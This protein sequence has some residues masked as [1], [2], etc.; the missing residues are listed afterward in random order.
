MRLARELNA[1]FAIAGR[2][3]MN[4]VRQPQYLG[5][6]FIFPIIFIGLLGG[7][8]S[9]NLGQNLGF[10]LL[11]FV[12]IGM[13]V[14]SIYQG[15]MSGIT[16]LIEDREN[17]FTQEMFVA[18][19]SRYSIILGKVLGSGIMSVVTLVSV[20]IVALVMGVSISL[21]DVGHIL[22]L[23]PII[24]LSGSALGIFFIGFVRS[25]RL[26]DVG[27]FLLVFPQIF[28]SGAMIPVHHSSGALNWLV[29]AMPMTYLVDLT[30][31]VF[32][33]GQPAMRAIVMRPAW[34]DLTVT[35]G[36]FVLFITVGTQMFT[37]AERNR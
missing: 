5:F 2:E 23:A 27:S 24:A 10:N 32:Y 12:F 4:V 37:R 9:Q 16:S 14:N 6:M 33:A 34:I 21:T 11:R 13:L 19:V 35:A 22:L 3:I 28:L 8:L 25:P 15:T 1:I 7:M 29:H 17:G 30:H 36:I 31:R 20:F 18:P 26:A